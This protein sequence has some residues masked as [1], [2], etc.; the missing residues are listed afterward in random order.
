MIETVKLSIQFI[1][2]SFQMKSSSSRL[3]TA[4]DIKELNQVFDNIEDKLAIAK[5]QQ[6]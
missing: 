3:P 2:Y 5:L 4:R 6:Q 1:F